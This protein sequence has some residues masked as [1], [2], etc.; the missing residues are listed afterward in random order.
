MRSS[1]PDPLAFNLAVWEIVRR[2]P[3]GKVTTY[4]RI[5]A[6][7]PRPADVSEAEYRAAGARW[8]GNALAA[9]PDDAPWQR[10]INAQG[11]ISQRRG[12]GF[13]LQR[14]LLEAE[15]VEFDKSDRVDLTRYGWNEAPENP[16]E[17]EEQLSLL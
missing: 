3:R 8:V 16:V 1:P 13:L 6:L 12:G 11:K 4:G 14:Q 5:A 15:G 7:I 9:C 10:V 2:I 17:G